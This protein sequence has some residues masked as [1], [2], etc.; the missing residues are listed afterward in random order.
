MLGDATDDVVA[1]I[2]VKIDDALD[3]QVVGLGSAA[4][5]NN[6][7]GLGSDQRGDLFARATDGLFRLPTETMVTAGGVA[8]LLGEIREHRIEHARIDARGRMIVHV[9]GFF[10]HCFRYLFSNLQVRSVTKSSINNSGPARY[11]I[12]LTKKQSNGI[13]LTKYSTH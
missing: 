8:E 5:E 12:S 1:L 4:G 9:Y 2:F 7:L 11:N 3:C 6:F 10:Q 13:C